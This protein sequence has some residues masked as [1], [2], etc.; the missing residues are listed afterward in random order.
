[1]SKISKQIKRK[2]SKKA[3]KRKISKKKAK[4]RISKKIRTPKIPPFL[5]EKVQRLQDHI[6]FTLS[7]ARVSEL[8]W[9]Q[10]V[11]IRKI[12]ADDLS[13]KIAKSKKAYLLEVESIQKEYGIK[14]SDYVYDD[15]TG[16]LTLI[17]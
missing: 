15:E 2:T 4:K 8:E 3:K 5:L 17:E 7:N 10:Q 12:K 14:L 13:A 11:G 16:V 6:A 1:M 9:Q